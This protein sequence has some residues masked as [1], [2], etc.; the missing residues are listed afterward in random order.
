MWT[1]C[2]CYFARLVPVKNYRVGLSTHV[3]GEFSEIIS[4]HIYN[5]EKLKKK[6]NKM[7]TYA[8]F[9]QII[10]FFVPPVTREEKKKPTSL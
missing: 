10:D 2:N 5:N 1:T 4:D 7:R 9:D 3:V 6:K 8:G